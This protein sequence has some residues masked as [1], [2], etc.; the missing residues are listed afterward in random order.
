MANV[1]TF[2]AL[3]KAYHDHIATW[4]GYNANDQIADEDYK[5]FSTAD[6]SFY[7]LFPED[8]AQYGM[9]GNIELHAIDFQLTVL[10]YYEGKSSLAV[11][12][13]NTWSAIDTANKALLTFAGTRGDILNI[14]NIK[15]EFI[16][17]EFARVTFQGKILFQWS[18]K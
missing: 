11:N 5:P 14:E 2:G 1:T 15:K 10:Y 17:T 6:K 7:L 3:Y 8:N 4:S 12:E 13:Q 16:A 18:M 9:T